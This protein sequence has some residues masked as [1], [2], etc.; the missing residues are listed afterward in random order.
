MVRWDSDGYKYDYDLFDIEY[1]TKM[2][3][4]LAAVIVEQDENE[5][6]TLTALD[7]SKLTK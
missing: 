3:E 2:D 7:F 1:F 4:F 5:K 6:Q